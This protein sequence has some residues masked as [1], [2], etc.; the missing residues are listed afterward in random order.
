MAFVLD[1]SRLFHGQ[2]LIENPQKIKLG[3][4]LPAREWLLRVGKLVSSSELAHVPDRDTQVAGYISTLC[5]SGV[6][7]RA[8]R[9]VPATRKKRTNLA[10]FSPYVALR[11]R[12]FLS[13]DRFRVFVLSIFRTNTLF[14]YLSPIVGFDEVSQP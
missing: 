10:H 14:E 4:S 5:S 8:T 3:A 1:D 2:W 9:R 13:G 11:V 7:I 12:S 6:F